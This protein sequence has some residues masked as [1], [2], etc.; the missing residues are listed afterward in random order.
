[1]IVVSSTSGLARQ[2]DEANYGAAKLGIVVGPHRRH[3]KRL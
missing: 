3:G 1:M 2:S